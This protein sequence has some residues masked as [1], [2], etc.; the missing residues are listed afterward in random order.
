MSP[1]SS[2]DGTLS[3]GRPTDCANR[4]PREVAAYDL[5]D[6]LNIPYRRLDHQALFTIEACRETD[7]I[8]GVAMCKNLFLCT[9]NK[10]Q[11]YLLLMPG[12]KR[13]QAK[14]FSRLLGSSRVSFAPETYMEELLGLTPGSVTILGLMNDRE[15]RVSLYIDREL[16]QEEYI[17]CHPCVNTA[18]V[19]LR[20]TDVLEKLL[21]AL[22]HTCSVVDLPWE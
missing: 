13:F 7:D 8:L 2:L 12:K 17:G 6:S 11:F 5:L 19:K 15:K 18:S 4:L 16:L 3:Y 21:P 10:S 14:V 9:Q 22:G 20:T 1:V